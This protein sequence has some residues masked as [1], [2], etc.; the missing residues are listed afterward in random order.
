M[1]GRKAGSAVTFDKDTEGAITLTDIAELLGK[2]TVAVW[3]AHVPEPV[4]VR[5]AWANNP[6]GCNLYNRDGLPAS[7]FCSDP[8]LLAAIIA[9]FV[10][11]REKDDPSAPWDPSELPDVERGAGRYIDR[12]PFAGYY[13]ALKKGYAGTA[14]YSRQEP[15]QVI[16]GP[17]FIF[18]DQHIH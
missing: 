9:S 5:Y 1:D 15:L 17:V 13:D 6:E 2:D 10:N 11:E 3:S 14:I 12:P 8:A 7:P 4:A 16:R 18:K